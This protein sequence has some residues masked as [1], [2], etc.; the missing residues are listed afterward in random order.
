VIAIGGP[1]GSGKTT[2][3]LS[4]AAHADVAY[5]GNDRCVLRVDGCASVRGLATIV[6]IRRDGLRAFPGLTERIRAEL[7]ERFVDGKPNV[8]LHPPELLRLC[9]LRGAAGGPLAAVLLPTVTDGAD[10]LRLR[11][12]SSR[13]AL[14]RLRASLFRAGH[15]RALGEVFASEASYGRAVPE[16]AE[17][18]LRWLAGHLPCFA[19]ELGGGRPPAAADCLRLLEAIRRES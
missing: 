19:V 6:S 7:P 10:A 18:S 16:A 2:L 12:L 11:R 3:L 13:A 15:A 17:N 4:L 14:P 5:V 8:S 9:G 1:K